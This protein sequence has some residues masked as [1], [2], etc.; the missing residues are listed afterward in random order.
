MSSSAVSLAPNHSLKVSFRSGFLSWG[1][2]TRPCSVIEYV[3]SA[4]A[5]A[6]APATRALYCTYLLRFTAFSTLTGTT[7]P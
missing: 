7:E 4:L 3:T 2:A 6:L 5:V 1:R